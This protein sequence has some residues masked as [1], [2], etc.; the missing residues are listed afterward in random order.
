MAPEE[1]APEEQAPQDQ[2]GAPEEEQGG[3]P[4]QGGG[5]PMQQLY[6]GAV[7][8]IQGQDCETALQVC[9]MFVQIVEQ[10]QGGGGGQQPTPAEQGAEPVYRRGGKLVGHIYR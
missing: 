8:A 6:Q 7:Q 10:S 5:D 3:A 1:Q 4:E 2:G 9:Q